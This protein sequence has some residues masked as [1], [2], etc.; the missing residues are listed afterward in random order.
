MDFDAG[1]KTRRMQRRAAINYPI[2]GIDCD[3]AYGEGRPDQS[4]SRLELPYVAVA[5]A[6]YRAARGFYR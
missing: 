5:A 3:R 6:E 4:V 2:H 1:T